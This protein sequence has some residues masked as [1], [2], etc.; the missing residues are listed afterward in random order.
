MKRPLSL[1]ITGIILALVIWH[2][3]ASS[4]L[5]G[6]DFGAS[7]A[8]VNSFRALFE[9]GASGELLKQSVPSLK[10]ILVGLISATFLGIFVGIVIGVYEAIEHLTYT[11]FQ[12]IRM[13]SPL[14]WMPVAIIL[15]GIG[16][17][18]I[19]FLIAV[20]AIWPI[21]INTFS[22]V[23]RVNRIW[24]EVVKTLG[25][26]D[27][28]ILG[29]VIIPAIIPYILTGLKVAV[30]ISWIIL[31]PAEMLGV[32]SGLGYYI[33]DCRDRFSYDEMMATILVIGLIGLVLDSFI[34]TL[35]NHFNW[36]Q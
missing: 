10:R 28:P 13:I 4:P 16:D 22:G 34:G 9:L 21:I 26:G 8:P 23:R 17:T 27:W 12:F 29:K 1:R 32:S 36:N 25:G 6:E 2:V 33:L 31:V 35:Q 30:G 15:L 14:A 18:P 5:V 20:A 24:I 11:P 3:V 19:Y 7:F